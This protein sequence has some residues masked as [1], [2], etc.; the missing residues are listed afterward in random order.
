MITSPPSRLALNQKRWKT[1]WHIAP[2]ALA[3]GTASAM[4]TPT[5]ETVKQA[6]V[7]AADITLM[8]GI[9]NIYFEEDIAKGEMI[10]L[11]KD[12]GILIAVGGT[13]LYGGIKVSEAGLA[14]VLNFVPGAGW[15]VSGL[16]TASVTAIVSGLF[17]FYC[18]SQAKKGI[19]PLLKSRVA[20]A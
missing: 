12:A 15:G 13:L 1:I 3:T 17:A 5:L 18:D 9:Y 20:I 8:A 4:P 16:I 6:G 14:E 10:E 19:V 2:V 11:L 7:T